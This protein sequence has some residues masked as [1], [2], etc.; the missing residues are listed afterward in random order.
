MTAESRAPKSQNIV[1]NEDHD[2]DVR[3]ES[4][5]EKHFDAARKIQNELTG[6]SGKA[7]CG[8]CPL[9]WC[10]ASNVEFE[11]K[12][13]KSADR[14]STYGLAIRKTDQMVIGVINLR[15]GGQ[16]SAWDEDILHKPDAKELYVDYMVVTNESRGMGAGTKLLE[17]AE[18]KA[19]ERGA[20]IMTLGVVKGNPA[21]R[22]Y[23]RFGFVDKS[24]STCWPFCFLGMPHG[25]L[26]VVMMEKKVV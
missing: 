16:T 20:T 15:Q 13:R 6:T 25:Q 17:W 11:A 9:A 24:T 10:P 23:D 8:I 3:I 7:C 26:G 18:N 22:L 21:K 19:K 5:T 4:L 2:A 14:C 12:F 1:R